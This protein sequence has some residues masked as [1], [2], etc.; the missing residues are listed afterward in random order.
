MLV[1]L[2]A[3][4]SARVVK[5]RARPL[6]DSAGASASWLGNAPPL[7]RT[8]AS[9]FGVLAASSYTQMLRTA[10][11]T[12]LSRLAAREVKAMRRPSK[13]MLGCSASAL[14]GLPFTPVLM[15]SRAPLERSL[16]TT[17]EV[18]P[19]LP[20]LGAVVVKTTQRPSPEIFAEQL[21][22][23]PCSPLAVR[24]TRRV[25]AVSWSVTNTSL[26]PLA[27]PVTRLEA[28]EQKAR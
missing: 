27:S 19:L 7:P 5:A 15:R 6:H 17:C 3:R 24:L 26:K 2:P 13:S 28:D 16:R 23:L 8:A 25:C 4:L 11:F 9:L 22:P 18:R 20:R 14:A 21:S 10:A 12:P 1:S